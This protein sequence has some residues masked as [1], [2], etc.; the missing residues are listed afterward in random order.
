LPLMKIMN[1]DQ[2]LSVAQALKVAA[3]LHV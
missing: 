1:P 3:H 2:M